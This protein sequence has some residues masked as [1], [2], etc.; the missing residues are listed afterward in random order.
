MGRVLRPNW[1]GADIGSGRARA[2]AALR[3]AFGLLWAFAAWCKWQPAFQN[4]FVSQITKAQSGQPLIIQTWLSWWVN[5][6]SINPLLFARLE[7]LTET[8]LAIG[9]IFGLLSNLTCVVGMMLSIGIW[10]T[11]ESFGGPFLAG[12]TTDIG[13]ALPY[14]LL[15]GTLLVVSAGLYYGADRWLTPRLGPLGFLASGSLPRRAS[16]RE[17]AL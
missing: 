7:A 13:T 16:K 15:F 14:A 9:L 5:F 4:T 10:S 17:F 12:V 11:A 6:V 2:I 1:P 3:V 8:A